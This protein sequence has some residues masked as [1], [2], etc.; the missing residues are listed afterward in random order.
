MAP[1][2][3]EGPGF[4]GFVGAI[5]RDKAMAIWK[6]IARDLA[7]PAADRMEKALAS[8]V[9]PT[10]AFDREADDVLEI[11]KQAVAAEGDDPD[12]KRRHTVQMGGSEER[13]VLPYLIMAMRKRRMLDQA[14]EFGSALGQVPDEVTLGSAL[15]T[16]TLANPVSR[17]MWMNAMVGHVS[18]P[19]RVMMVVARLCGG[20]Q[21]TR[22]VQGGYGPLVE[23][24]LCHASN[25]IAL[26]AAGRGV[27][28]DLDLACRAIDR[29]HRLIRAL[30]YHL[31][32]DGKTAWGRI[33][34]DLT[35]KMSE[36]I[37][38]PLREVNSTVSAALRRPREGEDRLDPDAILGALNS[39]YLLATVRDSRESLALNTLLEQAWSDTGYTL[40]VLVKRAA[41]AFRADPGHDIARERLLAGIKMAEIRFNPEYAEILRRGMEQA[42]R[43]G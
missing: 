18:N 38:S 11:L 24:V 22:I 37:A 32:I 15:Q 43:K 12:L 4:P 7:R 26:L 27:F 36:R 34:S 16:I 28:A 23:A 41:E 29:F 10:A 6:W 21:P 5:S 35:A 33:V 30:H 13:A 25:Q 8:G 31:D 17:A 42:V 14:M 39:L 1:V 19:G 3:V 40:E 2:L 9:D 20:G